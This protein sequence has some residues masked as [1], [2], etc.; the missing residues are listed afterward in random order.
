[1][2]ENQLKNF[3]NSTLQD[4]LL[5]ILD[6]DIVEAAPM[7]N[8]INEDDDEIN[9]EGHFCDSLRNLTFVVTIIRFLNMKVLVR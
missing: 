4:Y 6:Q 5:V 7:F 3:N 2:L 1:M 9:I 8:I